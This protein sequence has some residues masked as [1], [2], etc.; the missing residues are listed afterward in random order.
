LKRWFKSQDTE[1]RG[2]EIAN[3]ILR[4]D[5]CLSLHWTTWKVNQSCSDLLYSKSEILNYFKIYVM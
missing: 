3:H 5:Y 2:E 1:F 4:R